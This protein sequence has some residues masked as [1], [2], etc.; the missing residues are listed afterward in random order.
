MK[1]KLRLITICTPIVVK[2]I[3]KFVVCL[4]AEFCHRNLYFFMLFDFVFLLNSM[5]KNLAFFDEDLCLRNCF[6]VSLFF[7]AAL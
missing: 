1:V 2:K 3:L 7:W 6:M 5:R 4:I